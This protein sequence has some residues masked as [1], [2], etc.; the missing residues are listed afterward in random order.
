MSRCLVRSMPERCV[1]GDLIV[2]AQGSFARSKCWLKGNLCPA[3]LCAWR[4]RLVFR[5]QQLATL[6]LNLG[7]KL[8]EVALGVARI[9]Y[10]N[11][12]HN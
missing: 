11:L 7:L 8:L 5:K 10:E 2:P 9:A 1:A 6:M 12:L 3:I 4:F